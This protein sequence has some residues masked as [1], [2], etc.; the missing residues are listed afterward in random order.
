MDLVK[1][2]VASKV[3]SYDK[4]NE[5]KGISPNTHAGN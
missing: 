5:L 1:N 3:E 2:T 4:L